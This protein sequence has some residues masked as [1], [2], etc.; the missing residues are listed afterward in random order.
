MQNNTG[1]RQGGMHPTAD[2][3]IQNAVIAAIIVILAALILLCAFQNRLI[4]GC[5]VSDTDPVSQAD[6]VSP[7]DGVSGADAISSGDAS[8]SGNDAVS[9]GDAV[10]DANVVYYPEV[11]IEGIVLPEEYGA[12]LFD[13]QAAMWLINAYRRQNGLHELLTDPFHLTLVTRLRLQ[14]CLE[15]FSHDRPD[16]T[17]FHTA[18]DEV[19]LFYSFCAENL[20]YGQYTAEQAVLDWIESP[21]H[22]DNLLSPYVTFMCVRVTQGE[23][24]I[25]RW[26]F[27]AY[28]AP[29]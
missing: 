20:A 23:D 3:A 5:G 16:G 18:Y 4:G 12:G 29:R 26:V 2:K 13:E 27:E 1:D 6:V 24:G 21:T 8:V 7:S 11:H 19:G 22:R 28:S 10:S 9:A 15:M 25:A 17:R 14:E